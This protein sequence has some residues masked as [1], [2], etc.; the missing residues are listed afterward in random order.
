MKK[1][2]NKTTLCQ[3]TI[4]TVIWA[5]L[6]FMAL[7]TQ[8][9]CN[10][11]GGGGLMAGGG[12]GGTGISVGEIS[13]F[14]SIIVNDVDFDTKKAK[15]IVN[16]K[17]IGVGDSV[18]RN[19]LAL[20]MVV[21]VEG[22]FLGNDT[23]KA[24]RIVFNED[25]KGPATTI[26]TLDTNVKKIVVLGQTVIVDDGTQFKDTDYDSLK[27][28]DVLQISGWTD[29]KGVIQ[30]TYLANIDGADDRVSVKGI[31]TE[32]NDPQTNLRINQLNV[33]F[34]QAALM[35]FPDGQP[36]ADQLVV[37]KGILN[38]NGVLVATQV[39]LEDNLGIDEADDVEI[40][41]I[42]S[43]FTS[44]Q[45]FLLGTTPIRTD[46][47][48][49]F[50]GIEPDEIVAGLRLL[51]KGSLKKGR[52]LA[53]DVIARDKVNIEGK[54]ED[55]DYGRLEVTFTGLIPLVIHINNATKIFG[56]ADKLGDLKQGQHVKV[57][58]YVAGE[59]KVEATQIKVEKDDKGKVKLL[60]PVT[61]KTKN[62]VS[63]FQVEIDV[64][65]IDEFKNDT[66]EMVFRDDFLN[67]VIEGDTASA[68]GNLVG[69]VVEWKSIELITD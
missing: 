58:G 56:N 21:R 44:P 51:I 16:G 65:Q 5:I 30:A 40:E 35:G 32:V 15:V 9:A 28:G 26:E 14:G 8:T 24:D 54:V 7:F 61:G 64:N 68:N 12:I 39:S 63:V 11:S 43:Q 27:V 52:L 62:T 13:G 1:K 57:L 20:G 49:E 50:K 46:E 6:I 33:D 69:N 4:P 59:D 3:K 41:G 19:A 66:G 22:K 31:I 38:A 2:I 47:A 34:S 36:V 25:V 55:V 29:G 48:T 37:A 17:Q 67:L 10:D 60:G 42:V 18:V 23:G 53:D 45:T